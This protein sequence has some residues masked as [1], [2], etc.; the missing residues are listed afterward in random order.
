MTPDKNAIGL[1]WSRPAQNSADSEN[2]AKCCPILPFTNRI[3]L[4]PII[5]ETSSPS[6]ECATAADHVLPAPSIPSS[7]PLSLSLYPIDLQRTIPHESW[8]DIIPHPLWRDNILRS[9]GTFDEDELW[10]DSI[11]G[12]FDGFP[13][14]EIEKRGVIAWN[15]PWHPSGWEVSDEFWRNWS[16]MMRGCEREVQYATNLWRLMRGEGPVKWVCEA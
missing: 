13:D 9:L 16:W 11:G 4:R 10:S 15:P 5:L 8:V 7:V 2:P 6:Q 1:P 3:L 14:D 12:L